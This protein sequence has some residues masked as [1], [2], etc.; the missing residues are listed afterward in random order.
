MKQLPPPSSEVLLVRRSQQLPAVFLLC[1]KEACRSCDREDNPEP[2]R[3]GA[4]ANLAEDACRVLVLCATLGPTCDSISCF[5]VT[6]PRRITHWWQPE[7]NKVSL[8][9]KTTVSTGLPLQ[10]CDA[11]TCCAVSGNDVLLCV[12]SQ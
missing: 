1:R 3:G 4:A 5:A 9:K 10:G 2:F 7:E 11:C 12:P 6:P 8:P